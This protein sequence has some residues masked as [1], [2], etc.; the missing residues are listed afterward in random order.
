MN[1]EGKKYDE[2][3]LR[4]DLVPFEAIEK[5]V[6]IITHGQEKYGENNWKELENPMDRYFAA[7]MRHLVAWKKGERIDKDS[8]L[9][10]LAHA[11]CNIFFLMWFEEQE[12]YK[13]TKG[14][15]LDQLNRKPGAH[16][17]SYPGVKDE[18]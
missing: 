8:G 14:I 10:H 1:K 16:F 3:K 15:T 9:S 12:K 17:N 18:I 2:N 11:G 7:L 5:I 4:W 13:Y 6:E